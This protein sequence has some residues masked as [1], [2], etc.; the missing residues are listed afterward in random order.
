M[1]VKNTLFARTDVLRFTLE[2]PVWY[3]V[4]KPHDSWICEVHQVTTPIK[5]QQ[6]RIPQIYRTRIWWHLVKVSEGH[7]KVTAAVRTQICISTECARQSVSA[8][9]K[10]LISCVGSGQCLTKWQLNDYIKKDKLV[11]WQSR[12]D[13]EGSRRFRLPD[14][15]TFGTWSWWDCQLHAPAA[16]TSRKCSWYSFSLG[17]ESTP[18]PWYGRRDYV[19]EKSSDTTGNRS[20]DR[21]TSSAAP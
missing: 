2:C 10:L 8:L 13:P 6:F 21:P 4:Y 1:H 19:T 14:F 11:P 9:C 20:R 3:F 5:L 16:F 18:G 17:A 12:C 7:F 15:M